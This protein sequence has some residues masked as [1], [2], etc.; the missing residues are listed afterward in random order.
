[1]QNMYFKPCQILQ[2]KR[3]HSCDSRF[4][5]QDLGYQHPGSRHSLLSGPTSFEFISATTQLKNWRQPDG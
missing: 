4:F 5:A 1:M 2:H 3:E